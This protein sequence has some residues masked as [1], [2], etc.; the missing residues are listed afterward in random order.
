MYIGKL[1]TN[2]KDV[3]IDEGDYMKRER[4]SI[5]DS[6]PGMK[7][8]ESIYNE[9]G[10]TVIIEGT[11]L[12]RQIID[13]IEG[14]GLLEIEVVIGEE[15]IKANDSENLDS[16]YRQ[17]VKDISNIMDDL[18]D[19]SPLDMQKINEIADT[20][21][22]GLY[23][24]DN[25][26]GQ[27]SKYVEP[28][29][30]INTHSINVS[31]L[32]MTLGKWMGCSEDTIRNLILAGLLH[33]IGKSKI[34]LDVINKPVALDQKEFVLIEQHPKYAFE[35]LEEIDGIDNEVLLGILTHHEREDGSGYPLGITSEKINLIGKILAIVDVFDAMTSERHY[36]KK[37]SP[38]EVFKQMQNDSF[39]R[40]HPVILNKFI[41]NMAQSYMGALASLSNGQRGQI[42]FIN[43]NKISKPIININEELVDL[44]LKSGLKIESIVIKNKIL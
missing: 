13:R 1:Y 27:L 41:K 24:S 18:R 9:F 5:Y 31:V 7:I 20:I 4:I 17:N 36:R 8:A 22:S 39:G 30:Y 14:M 10:A 32:A 26:V 2:P 15:K 44:S 29:E 33:D 28:D 19:G 43:N 3:S 21:S 38:F 40:L 11:I 6:K 42:V 37:Q 35:I 25:I 34:P 16:N 12:D 23:S